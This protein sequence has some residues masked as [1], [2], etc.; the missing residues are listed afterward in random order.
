M[1][2]GT[3]HR[4]LRVEDDPAALGFLPMSTTA[5]VAPPPKGVPKGMAVGVEGTIDAAAKGA[6][7]VQGAAVMLKPQGREAEKQKT[8]F[9]L[10]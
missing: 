5:G 1:L 4:R 9:G 8:D 2:E 6:L 7:P 10:E 3:T